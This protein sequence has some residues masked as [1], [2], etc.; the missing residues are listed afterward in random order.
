MSAHE[1]SVPASLSNLFVEAITG[2]VT[3]LGASR[4]LAPLDWSVRVDGGEI[5]V[6][7]APPRG[8]GEPM[9]LC[10]EWA[11]A[12]GLDRGR[13]DAAEDVSSWSRADGPWLVE[14][15]TVAHRPVDPASR[16]S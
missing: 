14:L 5:F 11:T 9:P 7:G 13:Y 2:A 4:G 10:R 3:G 8:H 12:L 15:S 1:A 16:N 6:L